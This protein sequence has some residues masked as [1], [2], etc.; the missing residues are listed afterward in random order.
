MDSIGAGSARAK[1]QRQPPYARLLVTKDSGQISRSIKLRCLAAALLLA[2]KMQAQDPSGVLRGLVADPT[3]ARIPAATIEIHE[4]H[5]ALERHTRSDR[6]GAFELD[7]VEAGSYRVVVRAPGFA[8]A[9]ADVVV[10]GSATRNLQVTLKVDSVHQAIGVGAQASSITAQLVDPTSTV[11]QG[12]ITHHD[13]D[14]FPLS[15][16]SFAN[17]A[18]L[19]PGTEPVEPSDPTKARITAVSTGGSSGLNNALSVDGGDDS[20]DYIGGF[21]QNLSPD[22]IREFTVQ[23]SGEDAETGGTTAGSVL[24]TTRSGTNQ[25]HADAAVYERAA[26]LNARYPIENPAPDPKQPFSRQNYEFALG[27][28][29]RRDKLWFFAA[30]ENVHE[31][32]SVA[33]SPS[34]TEQFDALATLAHQ[35]LVPGIN[36]IAVP[37]HVD[38]PFRDYLGSVR[39]DWAASDRM[40]TYLRSSLDTYTTHNALVQQGTLPSTGLLTHNEYLNVLVGNQFV[41]TPNLL[42]RLTLNASG[43]RLTQ[44]RNSNLGYALAFPFSSTALTVSGFETFGDNQFATPITSFPSQRDQQ[45]YQF[46]YDLSSVRGNHSFKVGVD[47]IH[48]PVLG[49]SFPG[50]TET[51]YQFP[52]NPTAYVNDPGQFA[53][54]MQAGATTTS[55]GGGFSQNVQRMAAYALDSWRLTPRLI[56]NLG[57]RYSTTEGLFL[58]SGRT[59]QENP[60]YRTLMAL[61]IPLVSGV[62]HDDR[63][64][65]APR[66]GI[67]YSPGA[68]ARTVLRAGF[69]LYFN[70]LAQTGWATALQAAHALPGPCADPVQDPI[71]QENAGCV[72]GSSAGGTANLIDPHYRTPYAIHITAGVQHSFGQHWAATADYVHEEGNHAYR[73][74]RY[75]GGVNVFSPSLSNADPSQTSLVPDVNVFHSDNRSSYDALLLHLQGNATER[76]TLVANY[77]LAKAQTWGCV[78]GE[79]F[80]YVN[81]VCNPLQPFAP[82]DY[83]PSGEDVRHRFVF[84]GTFKLRALWNSA[85]S[86]SWKVH[87]HTRSLRQTT[88]T[89]F[90]STA[91]PLCSISFAERRSSKR[92]CVSAGRFCCAIVCRWCHS[93]N[94]STSS[95]VAILE[96]I[97]SPT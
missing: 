92:T 24:I 85:Q 32:A 66:L 49:G 11:N 65:V 36:S 13:L 78:L 91:R 15:A 74:Y 23:T 76:L 1:E 37:D 59:Q 60:G 79:L 50:R 47:L 57:T 67:A 29:L 81:G 64:Q 61:G 82:G 31:N 42:G 51:L 40:R 35:G 71:G 21:L 8:M 5:S 9:T 39:L 7:G 62:P 4:K 18:Y 33:Y 12:V 20:D 93:A 26:A 54:D 89:E 72:Q 68:Q 58:S 25:W 55:L 41:F 45:K 2:T 87:A 56:L 84:A 19:A 30:F 48:E 3:S 16:R 63:K 10:H 44:T 95:T 43:L 97:T 96:R 53:T 86:P 6:Q 77:T 88:R 46:R 28:P 17:I 83:G 34:S 22:A 70:D 80:D 52:L 75:K 27:G 69:G 73:A 94:S 38:I 90:R 14:V